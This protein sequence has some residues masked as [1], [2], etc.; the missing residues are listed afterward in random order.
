M[1]IITSYGNVPT[2]M[3]RNTKERKLRYTRPT[4]HCIATRP[5]PQETHNTPGLLV[6]LTEHK[7]QVFLNVMSSHLD[8]LK[9][10]HW[11]K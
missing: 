10:K 3:T 9:D 7:Q 1:V 4:Q 2:A 6:T 8:S 5:R 11:W